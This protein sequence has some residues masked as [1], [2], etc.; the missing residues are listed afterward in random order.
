MS[1][2]PP[3]SQYWGD[4]ARLV[5]RLGSARRV[6]SVGGTGDRALALALA[7]VEV[8]VLAPGPETAALLE[9]KRAGG[10]LAW[11]EALQLLGLLAPG[12]RVW[13]YHQI[14]SALSVESRA[15]W[16]AREALIREGVL[17]AG[18]LEQRMAALRGALGAA[19]A[20]P[21]GRRERAM[22][23]AWLGF[24]PPEGPPREW[25]RK[26][27]WADPGAAKPWLSEAGHA[28]LS[29]LTLQVVRASVE[30]GLTR[31]GPQVDA[32]DRGDARQEGG[33]RRWRAL[34]DPVAW[35]RNV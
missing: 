3:A 11:P 9:L 6:L 17:G 35:K 34:A 12:R 25:L 16:D 27:T 15:W 19:R 2:R 21:G 26:G 14:R 23:L 8:T 24:V 22:T 32:V 31:F 4:E 28:R 18:Q 7:G 30:E 1:L 10:L 29:G 20:R 5:E 13:L 33:A